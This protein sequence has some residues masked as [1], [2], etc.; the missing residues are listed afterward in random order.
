ME[1]SPTYKRGGHHDPKFAVSHVAV[2][3]DYD[4]DGDLI[5]LGVRIWSLPKRP[6]SQPVINRN[7]GMDRHQLAG[8]DYGRSTIRSTPSGQKSTTMVPDHRLLL[9]PRMPPSRRSSLSYPHP[10]YLSNGEERSQHQPNGRR[11]PITGGVDFF[12]PD[13][14]A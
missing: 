11:N 10:L 8:A 4:N 2:R 5:C 12:P 6:R 14:R 7:N 9:T 13:R 3:G 1:P